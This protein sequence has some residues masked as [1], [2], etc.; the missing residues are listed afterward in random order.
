MLESLSLQRPLVFL[1]CETTGLDPNH[2][3][4]VE[5]GLVRVSPD[6]P[7]RSAAWRFNPQ[8][9]IPVAATRIH[10]LSDDDVVDCPPF[11]RL[12]RVIARWL[13]GADLAGFNLCKFDLPILAAEF[14]RAGMA[15]SLSGR[16]VVD[17]LSIYHVFNPR[18]LDAAVRQYCGHPHEH[19]HR[20]LDDAAAVAAVL[21]GMLDRHDDLPRT[22]A[23]LHERFIEMDIGGWFR[24]DPAGLVVFARGKYQAQPLLSVARCDPSYLRWLSRQGLLSDARQLIED[25]LEQADQ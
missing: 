16:F 23:G 13:R 4:L 8:M 21:G 1:D 6:V 2:D 20:A 7:L 9:P 11:R 18:N 14:E 5:L 3:R 12:A 10:G 19:A 15:F 24:P 17:A 22:V 25:A